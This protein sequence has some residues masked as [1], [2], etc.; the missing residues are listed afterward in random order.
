MKVTVKQARVG[1]GMTQENM[2]KALGVSTS[3]YASWEKRPEKIPY[4]DVVRITKITGIG[5]NDLNMEV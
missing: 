2:A 1:V 4:K 5:M 3:K